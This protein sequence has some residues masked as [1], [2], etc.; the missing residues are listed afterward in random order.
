MIH[1]FKNVFDY[2]KDD[3]FKIIIKKDKISIAN[4]KE[5]NSFKESLIVIDCHKYFI[6]IEGTKLTINFLYD[7]EVLVIGNIYKI[8]FRGN[9]D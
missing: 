8:I 5:I 4:Y 9:H 1:L 7:N 6:D 3:E 2:I